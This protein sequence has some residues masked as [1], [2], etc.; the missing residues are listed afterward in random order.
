MDDITN[1]K[2]GMKFK[3][4]DTMLCGVVTEKGKSI[5]PCAYLDHDIE[6]GKRNVAIRNEETTLWELYDHE[7]NKLNCRGYQAIRF[8]EKNIYVK[9]ELGFW[10]VLT[11]NGTEIYPCK[12]RDIKF[13]P[14]LTQ[15][16]N[17]DNTWINIDNK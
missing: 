4:Q 6:I 3:N 11:N 9:N 13:N 10:G 7:G 8:D 17:E 12:F 16:E 1:L 14:N 15:L 5:I 2:C